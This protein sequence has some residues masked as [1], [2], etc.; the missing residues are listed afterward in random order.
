MTVSPK[1][2]FFRF[3]DRAAYDVDL[4]RD[5][6]SGRLAGVIFRGFADAGE[7]ADLMTA[8]LEHPLTRVRTGDATGRYLGTFHWR[9][10]RE[11][12]LS[13]STQITN[14]VYEVVGRSRPHTP[15]NRFEKSL[16]QEL[17]RDGISL[18]HARWDGQEVASPLVRAWDGVGDYS[19]VPHEDLAQVRDPRQRGF[20][21]QNVAGYVSCA[22]NLCI[23]NGSAGNLVM[24]DF[25]PTDDDRRLFGTEIQGGPYPTSVLEPHARVDIAIHPGDLYIFN[26]GLV[27]AVRSTAEQR[28][29]ISCLLGFSDPETVVM[30]T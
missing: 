2:D 12:Y 26:G 6:L 20:E 11:T 28:A 30:W 5:V 22:A 1:P 14:A 23:A 8:F 10:S 21:I 24:W 13:D 19:L 9:K 7:C 29:T 3:E 16:Q 27:H 18:R 17:E 4:V 25:A 15:W